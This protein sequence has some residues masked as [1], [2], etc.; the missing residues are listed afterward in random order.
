MLSAKDF[1]ASYQHADQHQHAEQ[2]RLLTDAKR[3]KRKQADLDAGRLVR[4][5]L[6]Y[7]G[8][9]P[10]IGLFPPRVAAF[11]CKVLGEPQRTA[12]DGVRFT[13]T[14]QGRMQA[15]YYPE[16]PAGRAT[17]AL[18]AHARAVTKAERRRRRS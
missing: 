8:E 16:V 10:T 4:I 17:M 11:I 5:R 14:T 3:D 7:P 9:E 12:R 15:A 2:A 1:L 18:L 6:D 13:L